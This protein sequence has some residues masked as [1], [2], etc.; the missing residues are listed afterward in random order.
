MPT[1]TLPQRLKQLEDE[2]ENLEAELRLVS[3]TH[4]LLTQ[5]HIQFMLTEFK[6]PAEGEDW[7][8]YKKKIIKSFV[9]AV[10]L[11]DDKLY[12]IYN[13]SRDKKTLDRT[14]LSILE[15]GREGSTEGKSPV[16]NAPKNL[17]IFRRICFVTSCCDS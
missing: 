7:E 17:T 10:Y 4:A 15:A 8:T 12:I 1:K 5:E 14:E 2:Q 13:I 11:F 6:E 9:S 3:A 16:P